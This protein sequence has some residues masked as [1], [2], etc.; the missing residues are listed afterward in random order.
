MVGEEGDQERIVLGAVI[1]TLQSFVFCS[2]IIRFASTHLKELLRRLSD[3]LGGGG[4]RVDAAR[5]PIFYSA[6]SHVSNS[7][8]HFKEDPSQ[9]CQ[10]IGTVSP[11][12]VSP[13]VTTSD[14]ALGML[15]TDLKVQP[16]PGR[17]PRRSLVKEEPGGSGTVS[18]ELLSPIVTP[19]DV[20]LGMPQTDLEVPPPPRRRSTVELKQVETSPGDSIFTC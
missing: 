10:S 7:W 17:P 1:I 18:P 2:P 12:L 19:S 6:D 15:Q 11:E 14:V 16:P 8:L 13:T 4:R 20:A 5:D 9:L 3:V